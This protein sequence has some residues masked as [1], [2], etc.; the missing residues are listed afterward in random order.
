M[1]FS[2]QVSSILLLNFYF[3]VVGL[4]AQES[5][6]WQNLFDQGLYC[7]LIPLFEE[8][9]A[10]AE[11]QMFINTS[12]QLLMARVYLELEKMD[13]LDS[14]VK[15][16]HAV[17]WKMESLSLQYEYGI[18]LARY[19]IKKENWSKADSL[20]NNLLKVEDENEVIG[21][22][23]WGEYGLYLLHLQ[24]TVAAKK[25]LLM[26][27][28]MSSLPPVLYGRVMSALAIIAME[29][30]QKRQ[31]LHYFERAKAIWESNQW[32][33][34]PYY[35]LL[36]NDYALYFY[37]QGDLSLADSLLTQS[38]NLHDPFCEVASIKG[39]NSS[40]RATILVG[41]GNYESALEAYRMALEYFMKA[42]NRKDASI[43]S[44]RIA[45]ANFFL[46]NIHASEQ[47][48]LDALK[49]SDSFFPD[50]KNL[51]S[52]QIIMGLAA[53]QEYDYHDVQADSLYTLA[54]GIIEEVI[55]K[56]N[57]AYGT[58]ISN[59]AR[60][61]EGV[62]DIAGA[63]KLYHQ[64]E[65]LDSQLL[66]V[67]HPDF[68]TTLY[69]LARTYAKVD[70]LDQVLSYYRKANDLELKL[71]NGYFG[72]FDVTARLSYRLQAM[73]NFDVF[74][75]YACTRK[76][77]NLFTEV[78]DINLATK[79][80]ALDYA[81]DLQQSD[82]SD[83]SSEVR[84]RYQEWF[85][86]RRL[87]TQLYFANNNERSDMGVSID[88]L[89]WRVSTLEKQVA[90]QVAPHLSRS[91][92]VTT[93]QIIDKLTANEA[94][95]DFFNYYV[96]DEY[97]R[98]PD[99][100]LYYASV[101]TSRDQ[102]P[103]LIY[104]C[105]ERYLEQILQSSSH[106]THNLEVNQLLYE[107]I[108]APLQSYLKEVNKIHLSPEGLLHQ[109]SFATLLADAGTG[110]TLLDKFDFCYY[111]NLR[112]FILS[113]VESS[114]FSSIC[115][116]GD[117]NFGET[118]LNNVRSS[119]AFFYALP[120]TSS[121]IAN[122]VKVLDT[123]NLSI[124]QALGEDATEDQF[125]TLVGTLKPSILHLATHGFFFAKDTSLERVETLGE[126]ILGSE[127]PL[128]RSGFVLSGVN[129]YWNADSA[130]SSKSD[131]VV[132][133]LEIADLDLAQTRLVVLSACETGRG[134]IAD[135]EGVFGLQ[136]AFKM[137]G[138]PQLLI[139]LWD[140]P[141]EAT[142][143]LVLHF[144]TYLTN[145]QSAGDALLKAQRA[146]KAEQFDPYHWGAF[147]LFN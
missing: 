103:K 54:L 70:S 57:L 147:V 135:G 24:K 21:S 11:S 141:D 74:F 102:N 5:S 29:H 95:I 105:S 129:S 79:N 35:W 85:Q 15:S 142:S 87:L 68:K 25:Y 17:E 56:D 30:S 67:N 55:G 83:Q 116:F 72:S 52:A 108:W 45:E 61:R 132:S 48:Y 38:E 51:V 114:H 138:S 146:L 113:E 112:D 28:S 43:A 78:Q 46:G 137:A 120:E 22:K 60:F 82:L 26:A 107:T 36:L 124:V 59:Y 49:L 47:Y 44:Y 92:E 27:D 99:S 145:G 115:L 10:R 73:G 2:T 71:L 62:G 96:T 143:K 65:K 42:D 117:P 1:S 19:F 12:T 7:D 34:S 93:S 41:L 127:I 90:R 3:C 109:V 123:A 94:A 69:N 119:S 140:V 106:Y 64:T 89:E 97:G 16:L 53:L 133:A 63:I 130:I 23:V 58:A 88:S 122:I 111:S 110:E 125:Y 84:T 6:A 126:R 75:S 33:R 13:L 80:L 37:L 101:M 131:G 4:N 144:Y 50:R 136:R 98:L 81:K 104:L 40:A 39:F 86:S 66:G 100:V 9:K 139:S 20:F 128:M 76:N 77:E 134:G 8:D 32:Q 91:Q 31:A 118:P 121:E 14:L 18:F